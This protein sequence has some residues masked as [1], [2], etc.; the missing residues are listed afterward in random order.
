MKVK[1]LSNEKHQQ[2]KQYIPMWEIQEKRIKRSWEFK[3]FLTAF[4]F[5][6]KVALLA[7][8]KGHH[9]KWTNVYNKLTIEFTTHDLGGLTDLD[10]QMAEAIDQL[11]SN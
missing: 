11:E 5:L 2:L 4:G 3:D 7:E 9:P 1:L 8:S 6:A 10:L